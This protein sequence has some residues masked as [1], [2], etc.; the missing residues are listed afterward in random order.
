MLPRAS[1]EALAT[2]IIYCVYGCGACLFFFRL[3]FLPW[4]MFEIGNTHS[5][6]PFNWVHSGIESGEV[7]DPHCSL[8]QVAT[9][10]PAFTHFPSQSLLCAYFSCRIRNVSS[11][12]WEVHCKLLLPYTPTISAPAVNLS[13]IDRNAQNR[14]KTSCFFNGFFKTLD[15]QMLQAALCAGTRNSRAGSYFWLTEFFT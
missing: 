5:R 6:D 12:H 4:Y 15:K 8:L 7:V 14:E 2:T 9:S 10:L 1:A 13:P 11:G 3:N